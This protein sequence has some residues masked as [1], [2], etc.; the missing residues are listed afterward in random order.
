MDLFHDVDAHALSESYACHLNKVRSGRTSG[1]ASL[2]SFPVMIVPRLSWNNGIVF[3][4]PLSLYE[5]TILVLLL[6]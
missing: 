4:L 2:S 3:P 6:L 1:F 5:Y